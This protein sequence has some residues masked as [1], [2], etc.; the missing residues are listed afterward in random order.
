MGEACLL[1]VL[2]SPQELTL[3]GRAGQRGKRTIADLKRSHSSACTLWFCLSASNIA[4]DLSCAWGRPS[5]VLLPSILWTPANSGPP[6]LPSPAPD[7]LETENHCACTG[8]GAGWGAISLQR[9]GCLQSASR[10]E[11][12]LHIV[13]YREVRQAGLHRI[14]QLL[15]D[16]LLAP[17]ASIFIKGI[18]IPTSVFYNCRKPQR[19]TRNPS[20]LTSSPDPMSADSRGTEDQQR[21][22][23]P[24]FHIESG[25]LPCSRVFTLAIMLLLGGRGFERCSASGAGVEALPGFSPALH[26][27]SDSAQ[28]GW[29]DLFFLDRASTLPP[30]SSRG[31]HI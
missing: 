30:G 10:D 16:L 6:T 14:L 19:I 21:L 29:R 24:G 26:A 3:R 11:D 4:A 18:P 12:E 27:T 25:Y 28:G 20:I 22:A 23:Y 9:K 8:S 13:H 5:S 31:S 17:S 2:G 7:S 15:L 1:P